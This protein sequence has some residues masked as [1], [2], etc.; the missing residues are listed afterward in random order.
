MFINKIKSS[1]YYYD[2]NNLE[3][4]LS[5][6]MEI[7]K[8]PFK[9]TV[10]N[11]KFNKQIYTKLVSKQIRLNLENYI[12]YENNQVLD[13]VLDFMLINRNT[14]VDYK[15]NDKSKNNISL[16]RKNPFMGNIDFK[17]FYFYA[18]FNYTGLSTKNLFN[19]ESI[20]FDLIK[21][22]MFNNINL[23]INIDLNVADITNIDELNDLFFKLNIEQGNISPSDSTI[24]WK[25]DLKITLV[26][27]YLL[28]MKV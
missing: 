14:S 4:I 6:K 28:T 19:K 12:S 25:D 5:A 21:S 18:K 24:M 3:N 17:P 2:S 13:G 20:F 15:I 1:R 16:D 26:E 11:D 27:I 23:N 9:V 10:K 8:I 7:F 22:E